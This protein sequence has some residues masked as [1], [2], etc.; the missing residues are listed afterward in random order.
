[1]TEWDVSPSGAQ[2][3]REWAVAHGRLFSSP[4]W[5]T[6]LAPL[7]CATHFAWCER[8]ARGILVPVFSRGPLRVGFLGFPVAPAGLGDEDGASA[9][10]AALARQW[11]L[12]IVRTNREVPAGQPPGPGTLQPD[13]WIDDLPAWDEAASKRRAKDLAYAR[14]ATRDLRLHASGCDPVALHALYAAVV[15]AHGGTQRYNAGYFE[16]LVAAA[17]G[18]DRLEVVHATDAA[19]QLMGAAVLAK[20]G[21]TGYYLHSAVAPEARSL[22]LSDMLLSRLLEGAR[23]AGLRRFGLMASPAG[24]SGLL[25]F[26]AKWGDR[27]GAVVTRDAGFGWLGRPVVAMM[28]LRSA[29]NAK[30]AAPR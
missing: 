2:R 18:G 5:A 28:A 14:R 10:A 7:G 8:L 26:K 19:G 12:D 20:D 23:G 3:A 21:D 15:R 13:A 17:A 22:G 25:R 6:V 11:R 27:E 1:M 9:A 4:T 24:Q 29:L 16:R 30:R